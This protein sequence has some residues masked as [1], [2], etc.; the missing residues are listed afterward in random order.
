MSAIPSVD[1]LYI[2]YM[3][4]LSPHFDFELTLGAPPRDAL[5]GQ[6]PRDGRF[7]ALNGETIATVRWLAPS[8]LF[9]YYLFSPSALFRPYLGVGC[10]LHQV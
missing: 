5:G 4:R 6:G 3:R 1:T 7:R 8:L 9:K 10:E 2:G